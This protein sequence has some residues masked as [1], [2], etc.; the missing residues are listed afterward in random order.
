MKPTTVEP[1]YNEALG[2]MKFTM[3][4]Q[5]SH[6]IRVKKQRYIKS[7]DQQNYLVIT[8]F[9]YIRPLYNEVSL[10]TTMALQKEGHFN[11]HCI[12]MMNHVDK[13]LTQICICGTVVIS[14]FFFFF[15]FFIGQKRFNFK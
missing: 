8:G 6:Y 7:W 11:I 4:H 14:M 5:V 13:V 12:L 1:R 2:T 9:C 10:Y 15:F 3:L